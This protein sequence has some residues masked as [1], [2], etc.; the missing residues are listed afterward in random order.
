MFIGKQTFVATD[1]QQL[2]LLI[3][4]NLHQL[5]GYCLNSIIYKVSYI[6]G[7][8]FQSSTVGQRVSNQQ[9]PPI[10]GR[11]SRL[12]TRRPQESIAARSVQLSAKF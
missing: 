9:L 2:P 3:A 10:A 6:P 5:D 11:R 8:G 12:F 7:A 1:I 4:Q